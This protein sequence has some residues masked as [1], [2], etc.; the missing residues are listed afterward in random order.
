MNS[1]TSHFRY[2]AVLVLVAASLVRADDKC[3]K[4]K[5]ALDK[6]DFIGAIALLRDGVHDDAKNVG[7]MVNLATA[8][9]KADSADAAVAVLVQA[10]DIDTANAKI[11][12][13][14]GDAYM[15]QNIA[16]AALD[17]YQMAAHHDSAN[18]GMWEKVYGA[19]AKQRNYPIAILALQWEIKLDTNNLQAYKDLG[20]LLY[21]ASQ[22]ADKSYDPQKL[23]RAL[24]YLKHVYEKAP[25]DSLRFEY[26]RALFDANRFVEF[27]PVGRAI[28][29]D[30]PGSKEYSKMLGT[31]Y[32][33]QRMNAQADSVFQTV[34]DTSTMKPSDWYEQAVAEKAIGTKNDEAI[35]SFEHAIKD[36]SLLCKS[37]YDLGS[38]YIGAKRWD[39]AVAM[40]E[41]KISCDTAV[42]FQFASHLNAAISLMQVKE[43]D[44]AR[45]HILESIRFKPEY[46]ASWKNLA[47]CYQLMDSSDEANAAYER[48]IELGAADPEKNRSAL[49]EAYR[50]TGFHDLVAKKYPAA[51]KK[52][53]EALGLQA[54]DEK[55]TAAYTAQTNLWMAQSYALMNNREES[56]KYYCKVLHAL[57]SK[58]ND[59]KYQD[60]LKGLTLVGGK[61]SHNVYETLKS[62]AAHNET[63][64]RYVF[65][66][67]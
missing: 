60:A 30:A 53:T 10:H 27:T 42:G 20:H 48:V 50:Q 17:Q 16:A 45:K 41:R 22:R 31:A 52:F 8:L 57:A 47:A 51:I 46:I 26:A 56:K 6:G 63:S 32:L 66:F 25:K 36:T 11:Y 1:I 4:G 64:P 44:R 54:K 65:A 29:A 2:L 35:A 15:K 28:I 62:W 34:N 61:A 33:K 55:L 14:E 24:P 43:F 67:Q 21:R 39:E 59:P 7:C 12:E 3:L 13:L 49:E 58:T 37:A 9:L 19:A 38:L 18:S 23:E 5:Q 40:F